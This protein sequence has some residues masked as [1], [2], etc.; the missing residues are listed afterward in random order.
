[1][2]NIM[3]FLCLIRFPF[4][5]EMPVGEFEN[6]SEFQDVHGENPSRVVAITEGKKN[7]FKQPTLKGRNAIN[8]YISPHYRNPPPKAGTQ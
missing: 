7:C 5:F 4:S 6:V 1:M 2:K 8:G 3:V